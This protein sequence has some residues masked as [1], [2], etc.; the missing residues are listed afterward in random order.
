MLLTMLRLK[1]K[2]KI[3]NR[4]ELQD[5][6]TIGDK[7]YLYNPNKKITETLKA[8]LKKITKNGQFEA[9]QEIKRIYQNI[10]LRNY[11]RSYAIKNKAT[12]TDEISAFKSYVN[13]YSIPN[14]KMTGLK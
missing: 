14:I 2:K 13:S 1:L 11:L 8:K 10:R 7:S 9:T 6:V 3:G 5:V 4:K 12:I